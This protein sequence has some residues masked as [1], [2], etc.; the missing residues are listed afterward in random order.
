MKIRSPAR[1]WPRLG[2]AE[3]GRLLDRVD[4]VA[5]GVGEADHLGAGGLRLQQEGGEVLA[6][7]GW[8]TE[9]STLPPAASTTAAVFSSS[10]WPKA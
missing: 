7:E 6:G 9:P 2:D 1:V 8:L 4:G 5:A 10:E 3:L